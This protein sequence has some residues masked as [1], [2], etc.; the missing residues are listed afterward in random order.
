MHSDHE[1]KKL[2][3]LVA[4]AMKYEVKLNGKSVDIK[5]EII[6]R[7]KYTGTVFIQT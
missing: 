5:P 7:S 3:F 1:N 2:D 4:A 6:N